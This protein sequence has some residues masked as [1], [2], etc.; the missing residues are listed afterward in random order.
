V[1][2]NTDTV[3]ARFNATSDFLSTIPA[4]LPTAIG[5]AAQTLASALL[6][7]RKIFIGGYGS[8]ATL[9]GYFYDLLVFQPSDHRPA[10]PAIHL[11]TP[12]HRPSGDPARR[13]LEATA[14][15]GDV[16]CLVGSHFDQATLANLIDCC[17]EHRMH[18]VLITRVDVTSHEFNNQPGVVTLDTGNADAF[19][20]HQRVLLVLQ[21]LH[22]IIDQKIFGGSPQ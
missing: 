21:C 15:D 5:T 3:L 12:G 17:V 1:T 19:I 16:L 20:T 10:L 14:Q 8:V 18:T 6:N 11:T 2:D 13:Q 7:E 4:G 9:A 22:A